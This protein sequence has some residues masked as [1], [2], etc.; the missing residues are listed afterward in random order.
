MRC[1][2]CQRL[3]ATFAVAIC[4]RAPPNY[5]SHILH[6]CCFHNP[7]ATACTVCMSVC[8]PARTS[9]CVHLSIRTCLRPSSVR[10]SARFYP[11]VY[12]AAVC[13]WLRV[14]AL[15]SGCVPHVFRYAPH[16]HTHAPMIVVDVHL[17]AAY[18]MRLNAMCLF[19]VTVNPR[20]R[21]SCAALFWCLFAELRP[22]LTPGICVCGHSHPTHDMPSPPCLRLLGDCHIYR[23]FFN[24]SALR[25]LCIFH[26]LRAVV[27][28]IY[29]GE[30]AII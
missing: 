5:L 9:L 21:S 7:A 6:T 12:I 20:H 13:I 25:L 8:L 26:A 4:C 11:H 28:F 15:T 14:C 17:T 30:N 22:L 10:Q 2:G 19:T 3:S 24:C 29:F 27:G 1:Y 23:L 18:V 16:T